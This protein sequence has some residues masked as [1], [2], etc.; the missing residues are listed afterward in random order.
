[1]EGVRSERLCA[2]S[3]IS[4]P[5]RQIR[6]TEDYQVELSGATILELIIVPDKSRG[7]ARA[8][9]IKIQ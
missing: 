3:G 9:Q 2:R 1:M 8:S 6:E 5:R 4:V 7:A